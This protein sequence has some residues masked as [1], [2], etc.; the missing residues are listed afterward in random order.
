M[1]AATHN[2]IAA[3]SV[4]ADRAQMLMPEAKGSK[5]VSRAP[6]R[7]SCNPGMANRLINNAGATAAHDEIMR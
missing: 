3:H 6:P 1:P 5:M 2:R 7:L 4:V